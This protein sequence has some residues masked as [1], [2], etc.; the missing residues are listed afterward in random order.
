M[1]SKALALSAALTVAILWPP[2][3]AAAQNIDFTGGWTMLS[4][5]DGPE[6]LPGP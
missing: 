3:P 6:R 1:L 4:H 5:V 2:A